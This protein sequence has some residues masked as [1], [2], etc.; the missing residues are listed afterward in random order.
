MSIAPSWGSTIGIP[1]F[2]RR[3]DTPWFIQC[4]S[5]HLHPRYTGHF[6]VLRTQSSEVRLEFEGHSGHP[7][8]TVTQTHLYCGGP[9]TIQD[10]KIQK[11][12]YCVSRPGA[13]SLFDSFQQSSP[14]PFH[15]RSHKFHNSHRTAKH[16]VILTLCAL[17]YTW[18]YKHVRTPNPHPIC[19]SAAI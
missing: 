18:I 16:C 4:P 8:S 9:S 15:K 3:L 10:T 17:T 6:W 7:W 5:K 14:K 11:Q 19:T 1:G 13:I 12:I 2:E